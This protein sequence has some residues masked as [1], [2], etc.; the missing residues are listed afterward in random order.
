MGSNNKCTC[1]TTLTKDTS[2]SAII[3]DIMIVDTSLLLAADARDVKST[4]FHLAR[5][6]K[7]VVER[8]FL[9][10]T[11]QMLYSRL[12]SYFPYFNYACNTNDVKQKYHKK[13]AKNSNW[14]LQTVFKY[15]F[16]TTNY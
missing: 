9:T 6:F 15:L 3:K 4:Q 7:V 14:I 13:A 10:L 8:T 12:L 16:T 11:M 5:R 1:V 2:E